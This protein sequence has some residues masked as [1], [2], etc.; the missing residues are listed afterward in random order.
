MTQALYVDDHLLVVSKPAGLLSV[1]GRGEDKQDCLITRIQ[2]HWPDALTVHRLDQVTSGVIVF[3]RSVDVHRA[4]S[5]AFASRGVQKIYEAQ[6]EG[7]LEEGE[8]T[9]NLPVMSDW[10]NRPRQKVDAIAGKAAETHWSVL[11]RDQNHTRLR[12]NPVTGRT[13][14][15]RVHLQAVGHPIVGDVFYGAAPAARVMLHAREIAFEHPVSGVR[16]VFE[17]P[18]PF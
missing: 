16:L 10:P 18:T 2:A 15:L 5:G 13:H 9:I 11:S 14:Q 4:L 12:L 3:A 8:G 1:P 7:V 17:Q 6:V